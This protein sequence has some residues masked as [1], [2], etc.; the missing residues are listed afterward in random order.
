MDKFSLTLSP[1]LYFLVNIVPSVSP[2]LESLAYFDTITVR[3]SKSTVFNLM[4][5]I[6]LFIEF[7]TFIPF[8]DFYCISLL[9]H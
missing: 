7:M 5:A 2:L 8:T 1:T 4:S 3:L 6:D 9:L